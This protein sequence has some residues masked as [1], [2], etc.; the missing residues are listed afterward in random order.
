[1]FNRNLVKSN[2]VVVHNEEMRIIDNNALSEMKMK[3]VKPQPEMESQSFDI[4]GEEG[5]AEGIP[6]EQLEALLDVDTD[7]DSTVIKGVSQ[8]ERD[9]LLAEIEQ[10]KSELEDLKGQADRMIENARSEIE[11]MKAQAYE[12]AKAQGYQDG[13][14]EGMQEAEAFK[15]EC[16]KRDEQRAKEYQQQVEALEPRFVEELTDIYEHI[17]KVELSRYHELVSSL[18]INAIQKIDGTN[19]LMV[20]VSKEDYESVTANK[21]LLRSEIGGSNVMMEIIEDVTLSQSQCFIETD[22][23]IYD[24]S[25]DT[26]L[27]ELTRKLK[28]LS[29]EKND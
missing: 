26:Q 12:E 17:F 28:L 11:D 21:D 18:L 23:G 4:D 14:A 10:A 3:A 20:H 7:S 27:K 5:F 25:L 19:N 8:E 6:S 9:A 15:E 2:W 29:Y 16:R 13:H 1:M 24:C 22:N